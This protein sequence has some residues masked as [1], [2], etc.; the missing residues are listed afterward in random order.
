[1]N[2]QL[3]GEEHQITDYDRELVEEHFRP[4]IEK[5]VR[6]FDEDLA[7]GRLK[8]GEK[9]SHGYIVSFHMTLPKNQVIYAEAE[10][11][12]L[13]SAVTELTREVKRQLRNQSTDYD[14]ETI[15]KM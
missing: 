11:D 13:L 5:L 7:Q 4:N 3:V 15:R 12:Q 14:R 1:M 10:H 6:N 2:I 9:Q 8:I